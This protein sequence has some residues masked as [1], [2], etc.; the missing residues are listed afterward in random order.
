MDR[1]L[2]LRVK[3]RLTVRTTLLG[4][5]DAAYSTLDRGGAREGLPT[6]IRSDKS[7][8]PSTN[9]QPGLCGGSRTNRSSAYRT[10]LGEVRIFQSRSIKWLKTHKVWFARKLFILGGFRFLR[11]VLG[12]GMQRYQTNMQKFV[13][14]SGYSQELV[15]FCFRDHKFY[16]EIRWVSNVY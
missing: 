6:F 2:E 3:E 16:R 8:S 10:F 15:H 12:I 14:I 9:R 11:F 13:Q 5:G 4:R 1:N 7:C